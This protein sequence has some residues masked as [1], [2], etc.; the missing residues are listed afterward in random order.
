MGGGLEEGDAFEGVENQRGLRGLAEGFGTVHFGV[1]A[2]IA[3]DS[4]EVVG[5]V[6]VLWSVQL[7][8]SLELARSVVVKGLGWYCA[9]SQV[10]AARVCARVPPGT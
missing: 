3:A 2:R 6:G 1:A 7:V 10:V 8:E 4:F 9:T 5:T